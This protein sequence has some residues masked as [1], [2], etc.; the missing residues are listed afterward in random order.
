MSPVLITGAAG[1]LGRHIVR[2]MRGAGWEILAVDSAAEEN[3]AMPHGVVY[4]RMSLPDAGFPGL[5]AEFRPAAC[6]HCAGRASVAGSVADPRADFESGVVVTASVL[7]ALRK[8]ARG[9]RTVFLSSAAVYGQPEHLPVSESAESR[10][11][12]PYG[13]HKRICEILMEQAAR[14]QGVPTASA[15]IF[16]AY[17]P[18][19]RRQVLWETAAQYAEKGRAVLKG[20]GRESRDFIHAVD[21]AR[22]IRLIVEKSPCQGEAY[23][24]AGG[25]ENT[26][27]KAAETI[28]QF[29]PG[30]PEPEFEGLKSAGD[31]ERWA[32]DCSLIAK[33][34]FQPSLTLEQGVEGLAAWVKA[35]R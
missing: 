9:C 32:A 29:F 1:F 34:G 5:V 21:V 18:G 15:R 14:L 6:V 11:M 8:E 3:A 10:P 33:I 7:E 20:T 12:S 13:Y 2:E 31:P 17:G 22:A 28:R 23:N 27:A 25:V 19:L 24:V 16:S 30:V 26:I 4:R 35:E